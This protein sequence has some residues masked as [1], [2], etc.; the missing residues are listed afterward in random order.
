M[1]AGPATSG[2][3]RDVTADVPT[4]LLNTSD[5]DDDDDDNGDYDGDDGGDDDDS[6]VLFV[7]YNSST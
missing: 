6:F 2:G 5:D 4:H 3:W 1:I 7:C